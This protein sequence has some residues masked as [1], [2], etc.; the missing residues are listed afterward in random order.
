VQVACCQFDVAW[1]DK[2]ANYR[3][4]AAMV[5]EARLEPG[6]L[7]LLPEMF[8]TGF[9]MNAAGIGEPVDGPTTRF[10][11]DL[12]AEHHVFVLGGVVTSDSGFEGRA[13]NEALAF[14]PAGR[15]VAR[16]AKMHLFSFATEHDHYAAGAGPASF[17]W[18][19]CPVAP[20]VCY[21][22]RFPELFRHATRGGAQLLAVIANWPA[23][24]EAH[25][26]T[27]LK[28][29]AV[30]NQAYVAAVNR[31]GVDGNG[32]GYSGRSQIID[33]KGVVVADGG[34]EEAVIRARVDL[35]ALRA[36]R[37]QF[38]ALA[39]VRDWPRE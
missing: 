28:A 14:D 22:L 1:E 13:R 19:G 7:L 6:T 18:S 16:Y 30:E 26:L 38:P 36:Y 25:W 5:R 23:A 35:E 9:S 2:P 8:A 15:R 17:D 37:R 32:H 20:A 33:P 29:R 39:D 21:D 10:L 34:G 31:I 3:R 24:R 4:V 11:S 27:L 12:A